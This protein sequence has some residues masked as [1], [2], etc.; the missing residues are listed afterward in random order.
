MPSEALTVW[1]TGSSTN[2]EMEWGFLVQPEYGQRG[3][4]VPALCGGP[5]RILDLQMPL[6]PGRM[7][8]LK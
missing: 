6:C 7:C 3:M 1:E 8:K 2:L 4:D 5:F